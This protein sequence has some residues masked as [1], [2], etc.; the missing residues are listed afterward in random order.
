MMKKENELIPRIPRGGPALELDFPGLH[1]GI[2]EY[3]LT[4]CTVLSCTMERRRR[5]ARHSGHQG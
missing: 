5:D 2:A 3:E 1:I 4:G